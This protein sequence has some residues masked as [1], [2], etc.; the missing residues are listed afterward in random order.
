[1][2]Q[3]SNLERPSIRP[4]TCTHQHHKNDPYRPTNRPHQATFDQQNFTQDVDHGSFASGPRVQVLWRRTGRDRREP[5]TAVISFHT[6]SRLIPVY[7]LVSC[8][9]CRTLHST[10]LPSSSGN[11]LMRRRSCSKRRSLTAIPARVGMGTVLRYVSVSPAHA[12]V[13]NPQ[14]IQGLVPFRYGGKLLRRDSLDTRS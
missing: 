6:S 12:N 2:N 10:S 7:P 14:L 8:R 13:E 5:S 3:H 9:K 11:Y 4:S 1:M